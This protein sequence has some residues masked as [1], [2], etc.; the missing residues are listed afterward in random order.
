MEENQ[1]SKRFQTPTYTDSEFLSSPLYLSYLLEHVGERVLEE[2]ERAGLD[3]PVDRLEK[4]EKCERL[5][6]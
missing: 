4:Y 5:L 3:H 2:V 6:H 1:R